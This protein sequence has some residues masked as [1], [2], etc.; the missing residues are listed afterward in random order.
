M[1]IDTKARGIPVTDLT[2]DAARAEHEWLGAELAEHDRRYFQDDA[3]TISDGEYDALLRRYEALEAAHT[4]LA[5]ADSLTETVGAKPSDRFA[6]RRHRVPMLSLGKAYSEGDVADFVARV[7]RFLRLPDDAPLAMT[8]EPKIDGLSLSLRYEGGILVHATTRGDGAVGEDVTPSARTVRDIPERL[9]GEGWPEIFEV[10][11]EVYLTHADFAAINAEQ[12]AAGK[13]EIANPR[14][15][16]AGSLR[17]KNVAVTASRPLRF[18][19]YAWG[20]VAPEM[21]AATQAGM[22]AVLAECGLE[23]SPLLRLC[24]N[25]E[26]MLA[27]YR[28]IE[29]KRGALGYDIDGVVYKV[30]DLALQARLG[31]VSR[32]PRWAIAHKYS[33]ERAV[34]ILDD[35]EIQVGRTGSL[36]P[37]AKLRPVTV[38]GVVVRNATL[39]NEDE[40][41]RKDV[42][43]GDTVEIQRAGDVIPQVLGVVEGKRPPRSSKPYDFPKTCPVCGS[44]ATREINPR[45]GRED[46]VRRCTGGLICAAQAV[47]RLRHFVARNAFDIEGLGGTLVQAFHD[48]G[49]VRD[50]ADLFRLGYDDVK[51]ALEEHRAALSAER[52]EREGRVPP[53]KGKAKA[54]AEEAVSVR[55]LLDAIAERRRVPLQ[56]FI[57]ALGIR[58]VG[59]TTARALTRHFADV[60]ALVAGLDAARAAQ[61]GAAWFELSTAENVGGVSRDALVAWGAEPAPPAELSLDEVP[62]RLNT[63]QREALRERY[64]DAAALHAVASRAATGVAGEAYL[65]LARDPDIGPVAT[66]ALIQFFEEAH[67]RKAVEALAAEVATDPPEKT[68]SASP[69]TG[70]TVVFT[71]S[72]ERMTRDE[73]K[74]TAERLGAKVSGSVSSKT[75]LVIAGPGAGSKL[76]QAEKLGVRVISEDDWFVLIGQG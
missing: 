75:D 16:A 69:V 68:A 21:P 6:K 66:E 25:V 24:H 56:R 38:G 19:A 3:P 8:A 51:A 22:V 27:Q 55:K 74:A 17:Q 73:A 32:E 31:F 65:E 48:R 40:I 42:R 18:Q 20:E 57:F 37:V 59:E 2:P 49:L 34:T 44:N 45:T 47:E 54:A 33:A 35:I 29:A 46:V 26:E 72:L 76:A 28:A 43:V 64:P 60:A 5:T 61:P 1:P 7:R 50:P 14:N 41:A 53:K 70:Q 63:K 10:R 15:G 4:E 71:G 39:H 58:H 67:N 30:D 11:G 9:K 23:T 13:P 36:T 12:V 52:Y 62:V